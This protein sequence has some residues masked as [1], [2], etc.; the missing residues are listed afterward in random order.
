MPRSENQKLKLLYL[1]QYLMEQSDENHPLSV[2]Q[3]IQHLSAKGISAERKSVYDD[4]DALTRFGFDIERTSTRPVGYYLASRPFELA[5]LNDAVQSSRFLTH[6]KSLALIGKIE[7]LASVHEAR[8]LQ[9]QVYVQNRIKTMNESIYYN[10]DE[11]HSAIAHDRQITFQYFDYAVSKQRVLR[12]GGAR[13]TVSPFALTWDDQNYYLIAYDAA[14]EKLK[15]YRVDK[16]VSIQL[17]DAHRDGKEMFRSFDMGAYAET[18]FGMFSGAVEEVRLRF[19]NRLAGAVIDRFGA[20]VSLIPDGDTHFTVCVRAA[21]SEQF[22]GYLAGFGAAV[23]VLSPQSV[24][25]GMRQ[26]IATIAALYK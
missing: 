17:T 10:V 24:V 15:H 5:E 4:I 20:G 8:S 7:S 14:A 1:A 11:L 26:H 2:Q 18:L 19:A 9:R 13:Y 6:K 12:H 23:E 3:M 16:M 22:Y 25:D 21:I